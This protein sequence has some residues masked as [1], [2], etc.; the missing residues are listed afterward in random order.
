MEA[1]YT[2]DKIKGMRKMM[3]I[4]VVYE[5]CYVPPRCEKTMWMRQHKPFYKRKQNE[6]E[7]ECAKGQTRMFQIFTY[8]FKDFMNAD[9]IINHVIQ[10][11]PVLKNEEKEALVMK[12]AFL[13]NVKE[14]YNT[15]L[16]FRKTKKK[17]TR[18]QLNLF[19][20]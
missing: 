17:V 14:N 4:T 15:D 9:E 12:E 18:T 13:E 11:D 3:A 10:D 19:I 2:L 5:N 20:N 6:F 7:I 8:F 16:H 1:F